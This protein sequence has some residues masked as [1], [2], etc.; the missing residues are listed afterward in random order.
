MNPIAHSTESYDEKVNAGLTIIKSD[1]REHDE[2]IYTDGL[3]VAHTP[4]QVYRKT[5]DNR[6][7][8]K[9]NVQLGKIQKILRHISKDYK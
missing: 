9:D 7:S 4:Q 3:Y 5:S 6:I 1:L 8:D 2:R